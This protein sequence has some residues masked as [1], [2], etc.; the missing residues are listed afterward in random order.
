MDTTP[1]SSP[2]PRSRIPL[3]NKSN[4]SKPAYLPL[5]PP[6]PRW[7]RKDSS[8]DQPSGHSSIYDAGWFSSSDITM[9]PYQTPTPALA[10]ALGPVSAQ[11][12]PRTPG[13]PLS[14]SMAYLMGDR[15][16]TPPY[17]RVPDL[18]SESPLSRL[19]ES[20]TARA[21]SLLENTPFL[22]GHGTEL[23]PIIE[24][25]SVATLRTAVSASLSASDISSLLKHELPSASNQ[26]YANNANANNANANNA[27]ANNTDA[28]NTNLNN[29]N[30]N[31]ANA[32]NA[33]ADY[34]GSDNA[35]INKNDSVDSVDSALLLRR[36]RR[37]Q[38]FSLN[39]LSPTTAKGKH[40][41]SGFGGSRV[42]H[43]VENWELGGG[44]IG[45]MNTGTGTGAGVTVDDESIAAGVP[46][47]RNTSK[48]HSPPT[49][50]TVNVHTYP[51]KPTYPLHPSPPMP[52]CLTE[53]TPAHEGAPA[54]PD[55]RGHD[56]DHDR[57]PAPAPAPQAFRG[58]RS[59]HGNLDAHPYMR[60]L[61]GSSAP[62][63]T[64]TSQ[65]LH[66]EGPHNA[67]AA[68][69]GHSQAQAQAQ[70]QGQDNNIQILSLGQ[71]QTHVPATGDPCSQFLPAQYHAV[72]IHDRP[73]WSCKACG[74]PSDQRWSLMSTVFGRGHGVRRGEDWCTRCAW[75]KVVYLWCCC[76]KIG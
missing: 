64:I 13:L 43:G 22:Y 18:N 42:Q 75:R 39:D 70:A 44:N 61:E 63:A 27:Y 52:Q 26:S 17:R 69:A 76:E 8:E 31:N 66:L 1:R 53:W 15:P 4:V 72:Q 3:G 33:N 14:P 34:I 29:A 68:V 62:I 57:A 38:S 19:E 12:R 37:R 71:C 5:S 23:A 11:P 20:A 30:T 59:A 35:T 40:T 60:H 49:V 21:L 47:L 50:E 2:L 24:Q 51:Q 6:D 9:S 16:A 48:R 7:M 58:Q 25:R 28:S 74:R 45:D 65:R 10:S 55:N 56:H 73:Y 41:G 46:R 32:N 36:L 54:Y 67:T